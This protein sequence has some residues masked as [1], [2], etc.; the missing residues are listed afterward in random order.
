MKQRRSYA[1]DNGQAQVGVSPIRSNTDVAYEIGLSH[2]SDETRVM[3]AERRAEVV[4]LELELPTL[5][6]QRMSNPSLARG[7]PITKQMVKDAYKKVLSNRGSAGID[8][9]S[10]ADY[11]LNLL[12]NL[13]KLWNRMSSGS[14]FPDAVKEV[15]IPKGGGKERKLGIPTVSDRI[16]Q[17]VI[18]SYIEPRLEAEFS[19]HSYGYRP[20]KSSHEAIE[21]VRSNTQKYAWVIDMDIS[22]FF[23]NMS[24]EKVML[25]LKRHVNEKWI[26]M[27]VKRWLT[28]PMQDKK[29]K[30]TLREKGTPQGGVVSPLLANLFLHYTFDK[31]F[32]KR[33]PGLSFVRY[34]DDII[35]HCKSEAESWEVLQSIRERMLACELELNEEKTSI[36]YCK[37]ENRNL[38]YKT[39]KFDFLGFSFKPQTTKNRK[40]NKFYQGYNCSI[41]RK[42]EVKIGRDI[43]HSKFHQWTGRTIYE[44]ASIF[45]PKI[46]GW[47]NYYGKFQPY[48]LNRIFGI[49]NKRLIKWAVKKYKSFKG[50]M[51]K[52]GN[53][54]RATA[55]HYPNIFV[56]WQHG[57]QG[58]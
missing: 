40:L 42:S 13:Y 51:R 12:G 49:F 38:A 33:Y 24:H 46:R 30:Q 17:E 28:V 32:G 34:A 22:G 20:L 6:N 7:I 44:I 2:S 37:M 35:V 48:K 55:K 1:N 3:G 14:Y 43:R 47:L 5:D 58:A 19:P 50:S 57:F 53:W 16:A 29:G 41:S 10:L 56:H 23:D 18:K 54:I 21:Q 9:E 36:V 4:Q 45:N 26:L 15:N 31:W 8:N 25:A 52:A 11:Q 39:V 27:Y